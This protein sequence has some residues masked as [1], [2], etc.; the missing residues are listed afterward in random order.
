MV[1][2]KDFRIGGHLRAD[3]RVQRARR[4]FRRGLRTWVAVIIIGWLAAGFIF[5]RLQFDYL[6][7][8]A[9]PFRQFTQA[10][11]AVGKINVDQEM[12]EHISADKPVF[13]YYRAFVHDGDRA[14]LKLEFSDL[15]R[16]RQ[17]DPSGI[18]SVVADAPNIGF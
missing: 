2:A 14:I 9:R 13:L 5:V 7:G 18:A 4:V 16:I 10:K 17:T 6:T 8:F 11:L 15:D 3:I 12:L 1:K